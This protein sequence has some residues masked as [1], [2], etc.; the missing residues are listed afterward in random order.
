MYICIYVYMDIYIYIYININMYVYTY[1]YIYI[2]IYGVACMWHDQ[3]ELSLTK[4]VKETYVWHDFT[5]HELCN[6][7]LWVNWQLSITYVKGI[8]VWHDFLTHEL[9]NRGLC[10]KWLCEKGLR[11]KRFWHGPRTMIHELCVANWAVSNEYASTTKWQRP[12]GCLKL[13][14]CRSFSA[15]EPIIIRLVCGKWPVKIRHPM[16]LRHPVSLTDNMRGTHM[17][18]MTHELWLTNYVRGGDAW[19]DSTTES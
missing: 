5:T 12:M 10:M 19:H 15:K 2:C 3:Q 17:C 16:G 13:L 7:G 18:D 4:Y 9:C 8:Y 11:V 1:I 6:R 14:S